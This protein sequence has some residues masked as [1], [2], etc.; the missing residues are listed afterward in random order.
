MKLA[1]VTVTYNS[2]QVLPDFLESFVKQD[3]PGIKLYVVDN[4]SQD[5]S[6]ELVDDARRG[7][8]DNI[9]VIA[10]DDNLGVAAA[11]N[12]GIVAALANGADWVV[13]LNNDTVFSPD[14]LRRLI[15]DAVDAG[16]WIMTPTIEATDPP[17]TVWYRQGRIYRSQALAARHLGSGDSLHAL[18]RERGL[19]GYAPTCALA[20]HRSVFAKV[21]LMDP[22]YFVYH[23]DVDFA[24]RARRAGFEYWITPAAH[25]VHKASSLTGGK[26]SSFT[27][28]WTSRNWIVLNRLN[29]APLQRA[30]GYLY[31][32]AWAVARLVLRRDNLETSKARASAYLEGFR[33]DVA[34]RQGRIAL[35]A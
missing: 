3:A 20:I 29:A 8:V 15:A 26:T 2:G 18:P 16:A 32:I 28:R 6:L 24:I 30:Y 25:V 13:L 34:G 11:N 19:V 35:E 5:N 23:D 7:G 1:V 17:S 22:V 4:N 31:I 12:Q 9:H 27:I 21:G 14:T 10:N 33:V